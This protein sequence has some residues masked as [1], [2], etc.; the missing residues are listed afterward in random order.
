MTFSSVGIKGESKQI[1]PVVIHGTSCDNSKA[2]TRWLI[3]SLV[4]KFFNL[5]SLITPL[6]SQLFKDAWWLNGQGLYEKIPFE[7]VLVL[8]V[9]GY[10]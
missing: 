2:V 6:S 9:L 8:G 5:I 4:A 10:R 1:H 3:L 7:M